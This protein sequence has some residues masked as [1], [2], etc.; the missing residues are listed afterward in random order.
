MGI[1][2]YWKFV[3]ED[4]FLWGFCPWAFWYIGDFVL[5]SFLSC[6]QSEDF[7]LDSTN[8][9]I[10]NHRISTSN[11]LLWTTMDF[12]SKTLCISRNLLQYH[13]RVNSLYIRL[14]RKIQTHFQTKIAGKVLIQTGLSQFRP[15]VRPT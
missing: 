4:F 13:F 8:S 7:V 15:G 3:L 14:L 11:N 1:L 5:N 6:W 9:A 10:D 12:T 2:S